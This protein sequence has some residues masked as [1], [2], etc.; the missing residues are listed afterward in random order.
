MAFPGPRT[1][2]ALGVAVSVATGVVTNLLTGRWSPTLATALAVLVAAGIALAV[3]SASV[4]GGR[5]TRGRMVARGGAT[6][7]SSGQTLSGGARVTTTAGRR[8]RID[9]SPVTADGADYTM[10][11]GKDAEIVDNPVDATS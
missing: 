2:A 3:R 1:S 6:I 5:R 7:R 9:R 8:G 10:T 11:A 4:G